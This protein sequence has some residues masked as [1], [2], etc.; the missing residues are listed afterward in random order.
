M[1][2]LFARM[3]GNNNLPDYSNMCHEPTSIALADSLGV[4]VGT[5][6][7]DDFET[8]DLIMFLGWNVGSNSPRMLHPLQ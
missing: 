7:L 3:Y 2:G 8:T 4:P 5:T 6:V 1:Y